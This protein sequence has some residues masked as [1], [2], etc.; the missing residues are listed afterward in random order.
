M[1][2][3]DDYYVVLEKGAFIWGIGETLFEACQDAVHNLKREN[4][5]NDELFV[6][7]HVI[8]YQDAPYGFVCYTTCDYDTF[9]RIQFEGGD[10]EW[11]ITSDGSLRVYSNTQ[12]RLS[13]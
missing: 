12:T 2:M 1:N 13:A 9:M 6:N 5:Y 7:N 11:F 10:V 3:N 4:A 8:R